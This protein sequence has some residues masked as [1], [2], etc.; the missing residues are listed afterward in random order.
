MRTS[1]SN[2]KLTA[3]LL[4]VL[5]DKALGNHYTVVLKGMD[6]HLSQDYY[7]KL[8]LQNNIQTNEQHAI[9]LI[10]IADPS[11]FALN[12]NPTPDIKGIMATPMR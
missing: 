5:P 9:T 3:T 8:L 10:D 1:N 4:G 11:F 6:I 7:D 2:E 12:F